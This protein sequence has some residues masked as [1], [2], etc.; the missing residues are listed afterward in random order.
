[1]VIAAAAII[2]ILIVLLASLPIAANLLFRRATSVADIDEAR[3]NGRRLLKESKVVVAVG[4][5]PDD[6]EYYTGGTLGTLAKEGVT[7]V[8]VISADLSP[9]QETRRA[10]QRKAAKILGY[11]HVVFLNHPDRG[12]KDKDKAE[13]RR[14]IKDIIEKYNADTVIAYDYADQGP[15]YHHIDHILTGKEAQA[16]A[17]E[18]GVKHVYLYF[19]ANPNTAVDISGVIEKKSEAMAAHAS[20][21][22]KWWLAPIRLIF[23]MGRPSDTSRN[24]P[25][26]GNTEY[27]RKL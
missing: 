12:L 15:V 2:G 25:F 11:D 9:I 26:F 17:E 16:A 22:N 18:T 14:Q 23:G 10:E 4:A 13:I 6:L 1:M 3:A 8:G 5:H 21:R 19:S 7:V 20:Q 24:E 27:F